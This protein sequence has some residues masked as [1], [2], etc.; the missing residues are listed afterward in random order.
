[1]V[2][3]SSNQNFDYKS[4]Y[5]RKLSGLER[6][7][8]AN[9]LAQDSTSNFHSMQFACSASLEVAKHGNLNFLNSQEVFRKVKSEYESKCIL[10]NDMWQDILITQKLMKATLNVF[11]LRLYPN[12]ISTN[13][14]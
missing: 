11:F 9:N 4:S 14:N 6:K 3:T 8:V 13:T 1:M 10:S 2:E 7:A 12:F 5:S